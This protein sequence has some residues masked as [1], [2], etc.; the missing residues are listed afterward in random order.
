MGR[1]RKQQDGLPTNVRPKHGR[2]YLLPKWTALTR[3]DEGLPAL[4]TKLGEVLGYQVDRPG[5]MPSRIQEFRKIWLPKL[6]VD[7]RKEYG[8]IYDDI[9]AYFTEYDT[10]DIAPA[11]CSDFLESEFKAV[12]TMARAVKA[13]LSTFFR[14]CCTRRED[15]KPYVLANPVRD[16]W[17][18][19]PPKR[20]VRIDAAMFWKIHTAMAMS[21]PWKAMK[22]KPNPTGPIGQ[23]LMEI[24]YLIEQRTTDLRR[25][26]RQQIRDGWIHF[27]P[28]KTEKTSG[29]KV[30]WR[31][32]P[33]IQGILDR[34]AEIRKK[35][36]IDSI[37]V[38]PTPT[39][40]PYSA[41]RFLGIWN[42]ALARCGL[43]D[44]GFVPKD[45][46][47]SSMTDAE[48]DGWTVE[49]LQKGRA[50]TTIATTE[51]YLKQRREMESPIELE[52]PPKP[53]E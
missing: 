33:A 2:Y 27:K 48:E 53:A 1:P 5:N 40:G 21:R 13:R 23:C 14:W 50:H 11:D 31:V 35:H 36:N 12:P 30:K 42:R 34:A 24:F 10:E 43:E 28:T 4:Y 6:S 25:L 18:D 22:S 3:I 45:I 47:P 19:A 16:V 15:G 39:G 49:E 20:D 44:S 38:F 17:L 9:A 37:F 29:A 7:V 26:T 41:R 46:L 8:R 32:T 51:G 52:L